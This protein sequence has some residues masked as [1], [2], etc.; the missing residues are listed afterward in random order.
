[1]FSS[2][3]HLLFLSRGEECFSGHSANMKLADQGRSRSAASR[4]RQVVRWSGFWA[5]PL[6]LG[7]S[8]AHPQLGK[9]WG[10]GASILF[11]KLPPM[12]S[13][14]LAVMDS[15]ALECSGMFWGFKRIPA[16]QPLLSQFST[17]SPQPFCCRLSVPLSSPWLSFKVLASSLE[18]VRGTRRTAWPSPRSPPHS[19]PPRSF[20]PSRGGAV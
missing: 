5:S 12:P 14:R 15:L 13:L 20:P 18:R 16:Q 1:M 6:H 9:G 17:V 2:F 3:S 11:P 4:G 19:S 10:K 8:H 7:S